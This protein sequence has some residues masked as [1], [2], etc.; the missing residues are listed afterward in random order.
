MYFANAGC[1]DDQ[2]LPGWYHYGMGR[3]RFHLQEYPE[4]CL[5]MKRAIR[6][7]LYPTVRAKALLTLGESMIRGHL[8]VL[9]F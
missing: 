4:A 8:S 6:G 1:Q 7:D 3:A 2:E 5:H 9:R